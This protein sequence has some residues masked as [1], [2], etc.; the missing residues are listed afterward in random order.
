M[1]DWIDTC[2]NLYKYTILY[3]H[4]NSCLMH[5]RDATVCQYITISWYIKPVIQYWYKLSCIHTSNIGTYRISCVIY[6]LHVLTLILHIICV[7]HDNWCCSFMPA[8]Q[9]CNCGRYK[10]L[11]F[12][13]DGLICPSAEFSHTVSC[14]VLLY[15]DTKEV[16]YRY[17]QN[18]YHCIS[19]V[20]L[21]NFGCRTSLYIYI[22]L[23]SCT[24]KCHYASSKLQHEIYICI[25]SLCA[26]PLT[27]VD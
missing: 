16:I 12:W 24:H 14:S 9:F 22:S 20:Q 3:M 13:K 19:N 26:N 21:R 6:I 15:H 17:T 11:W 27:Y 7:L 4:L 18:V 10:A 23:K 5:S 8:L 25:R 1:C 2:I